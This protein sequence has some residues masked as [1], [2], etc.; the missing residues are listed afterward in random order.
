MK[1]LAKSVAV[2]VNAQKNG[3]LSFQPIG[4]TS[5]MATNGW[6]LGKRGRTTANSKDA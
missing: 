5:G 6:W 1:P 2:S 3:G 4:R